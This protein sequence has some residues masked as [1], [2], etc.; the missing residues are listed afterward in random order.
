[1]TKNPWIRFILVIVI[2]IGSALLVATHIITDDVAIY[3]T[4]FYVGIFTFLLI[5]K[6]K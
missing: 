4:G 1:M 2:D 6:E 5:Y 3:A